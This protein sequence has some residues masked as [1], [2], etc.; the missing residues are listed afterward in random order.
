MLNGRGRYRIFIYLFA[1]P[2]KTE[3]DFKALRFSTNHSPRTTC[4]FKVHVTH[5]LIRLCQRP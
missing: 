4:T 1:I 3:Y 5:N 2:R